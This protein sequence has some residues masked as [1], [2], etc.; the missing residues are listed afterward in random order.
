MSY[1]ENLDTIEFVWILQWIS[2]KIHSNPVIP[3]PPPPP[4]KR[5]LKENAAA[6]NLTYLDLSNS[7]EQ[8]ETKNDSSSISSQSDEGD[9]PRIEITDT[10]DI[11]T[12]RLDI[13]HY[14]VKQVSEIFK[15]LGMDRYI[16]KFESEMIDGE[17]LMCLDNDILM[18]DFGM[19]KLH[20]MKLKK[21]LEGWRPKV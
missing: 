10:D 8:L 13:S 21:Y 12:K 9:V 5:D 3:P 14:S 1:F 20:C 11:P 2:E 7:G 18:A 4:P 15:E 16:V 19:N 6:N 17:M